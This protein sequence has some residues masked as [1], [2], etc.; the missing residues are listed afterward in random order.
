M[1]HPLLEFCRSDAQTKTITAWA[2]ANCSGRKAALN[3]GM[4]HQTINDAV[5]R[6][7][8][9][10]A[11]RGY[12][13]DH[14]MTNIVPEGFA[15]KGHSTM[16]DAEG[17]VKLQW[18][19]TCQAQEDLEAAMHA[20]MQGFA[21]EI[22]RVES[23][24]EAVAKSY[25]KDIINQY[26][27]TDYHM[28]MLCWSEETRGDDWDLD[29]AE[30]L[31]IKW[32]AASINAAPDSEKCIFAQLGD[33]LHWDGLEAVTPAS[34][35]VLDADTRFQKLVRVAIRT[36][37]RIVAMLLEKHSEV[38]II[39]ADANHDPAS[40]IWLREWLYAHYDNEPRVTVDNSADTYYCYEFGLNSL[41]Y[42][43]G[44]KKRGAAL[45][46]VLVAKFRE[47]FGRTKFSV[48]H[49]GHLHNKEVVST[50]L[51]KIEQHETLA[52]AD[53]YASRGGWVSD[54]SAQVITYHRL[55]GECGRIRKTPAMVL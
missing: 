20:A 24:V 39:M 33:F 11:S 36:I 42:H 29:I 16:Y 10:A 6:V 47:V 38:H 3:L 27:I 49:T 41:F 21:A 35:N 5:R 2:D 7:K 23:V 51:M 34:G 50:N 28:G 40:G 8:T 25:N 52:S 46:D 9:Y 26:T 13:P 18:V 22:P 43:H 32:F 30:D 37:R 17:K 45:D 12:S 14:D 1:K 19:K 4:A 31:I 54:R 53:A 15:I 44:H 55:Y 48:C